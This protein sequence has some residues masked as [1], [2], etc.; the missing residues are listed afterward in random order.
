MNI[1]L[2]ASSKSRT[3]EDKSEHSVLLRIADPKSNVYDFGLILLEII[4]GKLPYSEEKG[5]L[6]DLVNRV[7]PSVTQI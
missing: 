3:G 6:V 2:G 4:S 7:T 5:A 1:W